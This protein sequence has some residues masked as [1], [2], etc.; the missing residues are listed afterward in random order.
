MKHVLELKT[1]ASWW[2]D[3]WREGLPVGNGYTGASLYGGAK[4]EILQL[5]RHDF[6]YGGQDTPVPDVH[7][8]FERMRRKMDAGDF[9]S[10]SWEVVNAL[11]EKG[12]GSALESHSP[13]ARLIVQQEPLCGFDH[14]SRSLDMRRA[15]AAQRWRDGGVQMSRE[16]FVSRASDE[17]I[18]RLCAQADPCDTDRIAYQV[19]LEAYR[20]DGEKPKPAMEAIW[21]A[22][23]EQAV[24]ESDREG[25]LYFNASRAKPG[26]AAQDFGAVARV[27]VSEG[28][29]R[30]VRGHLEI[31]GARQVLIAVRLYVDQPRQQAWQALTAQM[32]GQNASFEAR[33]DQS[34]AL[35]RAL[36]ESASFSLDGVC[37]ENANETLTMQAFC[38]KQSPELIEKLW[39]FGRYLFICG[40][41]PGANPFPLYG[42]WAGCYQPMWCHNMANE[43]LQMIYWH[44]FTGNLLPCHEAVFQY[45]N[46]R[47]PAFE[48]NARKLFGLDGIYMTAGTTP[49]VS[50][51]TQVVPV[52]INWVGAAGWI[53]QHYWRYFTYTQDWTYARQV[54]AP[55]LDGV[56]RFYEGFVR[57]EEKDGKEQIRFYP[58]V[59]PENTPKNF[60]PPDGVQMAHPMPTTI[61]STIDLAILKE[62]FTN[63]LTFDALL[64]QQGE[65]GFDPGRTAL[66]QK[67][68]NAIGP[69][70]V[71]ADGAVREWQDDRFLDR[72]D[73]RHLSHLYPVFPGQEINPIRDPQ[74][75]PP[76]IQAV[77]LRK[78]D[79]QTGWSMAHMAAIYARFGDGGAAMRTLDNLAKSAL[80]NNFFTLHNDWRGMNISLCMDPAPVQ[81]DALMGY[82]NAVQEMLLY[83]APGFL[84]LLPAL[85]PRLYAGA[86]SHFRY[87]DGEADVRWDAPKG[88][89][90]AVLRPVRPHTMT[91]ALPAFAR[92]PRFEGAQA[93]PAGENC[94]QVTLYHQALCITC[95]PDAQ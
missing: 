75:L 88:Q 60:M 44:C 84:A 86:F 69:Y 29:V 5:S 64:K 13:L 16:V 78:I 74:L 33:L 19:S 47:I 2:H 24:C 20:N 81:L 62:F 56:A 17:V 95:E 54:M 71:N 50:S 6:W 25:W 14:F 30:A 91:L 7:E 4:R 58:S 49:G 92:N 18:Y 26:Q 55:Y 12:Y 61:N 9:Q 41:A 38:E 8:A 77:H 52:I 85:E 15:L 42:L 46:A 31:R 53:A 23:Q 48:N 40:S 28:A 45:M 34:A 10:A 90:Q 43:N 73:H 79:A 80:L 21:A 87:P 70:R 66:W 68:L 59:S 82:V 32:A 11:K 67:V 57:F 65:A 39:H 3:L 72:Y 63:L 35:H 76:Y 27:C 37:W 51:P 83:A 1:P 22:A 93:V 94:W 36:Y 89:L